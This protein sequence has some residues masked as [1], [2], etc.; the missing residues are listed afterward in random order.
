[1]KPNTHRMF[2]INQ[3]LTSTSDPELKTP[4]TLQTPQCHHSAQRLLQKCYGLHCWTLWSLS[5]H[6][7]HNL[8]M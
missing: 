7:T 3:D 2:I 4:I 1:M 6:M 8:C 5:F